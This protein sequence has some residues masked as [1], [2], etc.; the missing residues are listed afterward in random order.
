MDIPTLERERA[1]NR[2]QDVPESELDLGLRGVDDERALQSGDGVGC[3][4]DGGGH[5]EREKRDARQLFHRVSICQPRA[6][7]FVT[8]SAGAS[9][10]TCMAS[11]CVKSRGCSAM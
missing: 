10:P 4:R 11:I 6:S 9:W 2:V 7:P 5:K 3:Q 8:K 1:V